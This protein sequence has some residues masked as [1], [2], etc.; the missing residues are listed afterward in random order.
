MITIKRKKFWN[1]AILVLLSPVYIMFIGGASIG[2]FTEPNIP[3][4]LFFLL[5]LGISYFGLKAYYRGALKIF[6]SN[7]EFE[8]H[9]DHLKVF[10]NLRYSEIPYTDILKCDSYYASGSLLGLILKN[11]SRVR[12]KINSIQR[13]RFERVIKIDF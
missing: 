11:E 1:V 5:I 10:D 3:T 8:L 6:S 9:D 13:R 4:K 12:G 2:I 7:P